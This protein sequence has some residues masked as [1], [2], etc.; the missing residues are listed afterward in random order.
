MRLIHVVASVGLCSALACA[1]APATDLTRSGWYRAEL[2]AAGGEQIPFFLELPD[3]CAE[4]TATV[5]NGEERIHAACTLG[6]GE[7]AIDFPVYGTSINAAFDG[8][9]VRGSWDRDLPSGR[10]PVMQ[11]S[12]RQ[13]ARPDPAARFRQENGAPSSGDRPNLSGIWRFDIE[14]LGVG[15]GVLGQA[16]SGVVRGTIESPAEYGDLRFLAGN[17]IGDRVYLSTFDGQHAVLISGSAIGQ[18]TIQGEAIVGDGRRVWFVARRDDDFTLEDPL[19]RVRAVSSDNQIGLEQLGRPPYA[20][21]PT[22]VELFGTWC[23]N[24]NDLAP[25]LVELY[26]T[27]H[28]DGLEIL[29]VAY[30]MASDPA[31]N[32]RRL[33]AYEARHGVDWEIL[34][35]EITAA[36]LP[37]NGPNG[38][39]TVDGVPVTIF[40]NR[41]GTVQGVYTGFSGPAAGAAHR[42]AVAEFR[43][44]T[45]EILASP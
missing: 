24:C 30:E 11:F 42:E 31:Y 1:E 21:N 37:L 40:I 12:A 25:I 15:R 16:T 29:A 33:Q 2:V 32:E 43:R 20:G 45:R 34:Q 41:D 18:D 8:Q 26:R 27:H 5:V 14:E 36:E 23:P 38:L 13:V 35:S 39:S 44:L 17:V 4:H 22:I 7:L 19:T 6:T 3:D 10:E 9:E 28:D